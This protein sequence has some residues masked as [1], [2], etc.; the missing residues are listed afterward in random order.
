MAS[1]DRDL[2][3]FVQKLEI[4]R[5]L[6]LSFCSLRLVGVIIGVPV[7]FVIVPLIILT[8]VIRRLKMEVIAKSVLAV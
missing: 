4:R 6:I 3:F 2:D 7:G 1:K 5:A 8:I